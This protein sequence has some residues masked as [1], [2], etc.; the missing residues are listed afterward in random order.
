M[1]KKAI[2][3]PHLGPRLGSFLK[4]NG[5]AS[6]PRIPEMKFVP[7]S[8][9]RSSS[10]LKT[11]MACRGAYSAASNNHWGKKSTNSFGYPTPGQGEDR[12]FELQKN[13]PSEVQFELVGG[14]N[15]FEKY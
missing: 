3:H 2:Q 13:K 8:L 10:I 11:I 14:F 9:P 7:A 4:G 15:P 12:P 5:T 1:Q 6:I